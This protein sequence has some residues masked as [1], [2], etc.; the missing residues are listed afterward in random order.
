MAA[1]APFWCVGKRGR[2]RRNTRRSAAGRRRGPPAPRPPAEGRD[3]PRKIPSPARACPAK[4]QP[5]A[6]PD[7]ERRA[8]EPRPREGDTAPREATPREG[9][10]GSSAESRSLRICSRYVLQNGTWGKLSSPPD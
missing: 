9:A 8:E 3:E 6:R 10:H 1:Q 5:Y 2:E 7:R 4:R